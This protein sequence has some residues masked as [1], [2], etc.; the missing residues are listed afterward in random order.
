MNSILTTPEIRLY[1]RAVR[2][3]L[4]DLTEEDTRSWSV[5]STPT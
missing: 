4:E 5:G 3:R 1:V 2:E